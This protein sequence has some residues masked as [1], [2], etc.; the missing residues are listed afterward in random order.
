MLNGLVGMLGVGGGVATNFDS[1]ATQTVGAGGSASITFSSIPSTYQH[2]QIRAIA[3]VTGAVTDSNFVAYFNTDT[4]SGNYPQHTLYGTG[5][6]AASGYTASDSNLA[7]GRCPGASSTA[8]RFG[9]GICDIL[10]YANTN[11]FKT[12][13]SLAAQDQNGSGIILLNSGLWRSTAAINS[14]TIS[15][16]SGNGNLAQYSHF[17]LYGIKA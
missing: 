10:D 8:D 4:T 14:I 1:I 2:L 12:T 13:R 17:A 3:R 15:A 5:A 16:Q 9:V 11:K 6:S 7:I